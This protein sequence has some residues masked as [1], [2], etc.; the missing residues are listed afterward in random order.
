MEI[1]RQNPL[2][3]PNRSNTLGQQARQFDGVSHAFVV[4]DLISLA[5]S[6]YLLNAGT[7]MSQGLLGRQACIAAVED[8][9][10]VDVDR[11][12]RGLNIVPI[13]S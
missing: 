2:L 3:C 13:V 10:D 1:F 9:K 7:V 12:D 8:E 5:G 11:C 4:R 6:E